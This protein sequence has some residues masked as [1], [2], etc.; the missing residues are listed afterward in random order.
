MSKKGRQFFQQEKKGVT[1]KCTIPWSG[2]VMALCILPNHMFY[3]LLDD[4]K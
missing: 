2:D 3:M 1:V 4:D